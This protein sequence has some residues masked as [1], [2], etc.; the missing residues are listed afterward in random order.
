M[1]HVAVTPGYRAAD[2]VAG[3]LPP[4]TETTFATRDPIDRPLSVP[5]APGD[6]PSPR[7]EATD[8]D[9]IARYYA[10]HGYCHP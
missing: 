3:A 6:D 7:F 4:M 8:T 10:E 5:V 1:A 9:A 2:R